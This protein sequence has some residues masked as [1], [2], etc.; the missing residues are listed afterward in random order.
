M[1]I[2]LSWSGDLSL[3][4][5]LAFRDWL[6]SVIQAVKPYVSS[7]D[8]DKGTRW[9]TDIAK[10]LEASLY[11]ILCI[12]P[13]NMSAPWINFEA[14]A[15]SKTI[16]KA[17]VSP[18]LFN[19]KRSEVQGPLLQFQ[20]TVN[21]KE[22]VARL[23]TSINRRL[24]PKDKLDDTL[25]SKSFDVWWP[26][27]R[28]QLDALPPEDDQQSLVLR[29]E[30]TNK[31]AILEELLEL[32][33]NQQKLLRS[34]ESLLPPD[35]LEFVLRKRLRPSLEA[36]DGSFHHRVMRVEKLVRQLRD[37]LPDSS[38]VDELT[39][40]VERLHSIAHNLERPARRIGRPKVIEAE[41]AEKTE[42]E[43]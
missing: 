39:F 43:E 35:Y 42:T 19:V 28:E 30:A 21:E 3:K 25:L 38:A 37:T 7:E 26:Q 10:E 4:I 27:L 23:I 1:K 15:L 32:A 34:P 12:T 41:V 14:G 31:D 17:N 33:R 24:E 2:F 9:S 36:R 11:G 5:A 29:A 20:S 16:D 6:P 18:F 22:D 13:S 40:E 8:I